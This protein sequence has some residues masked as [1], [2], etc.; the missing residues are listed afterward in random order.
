MVTL[1]DELRAES[2]AVNCN[3]YVPAAVKL[4]FVSAEVGLLNTADAGPLT[5]CHA[6][7]RAPPTGNPS[8]STTPR[9]TAPF[10]RVTVWTD[11]ASTKGALLLAPFQTPDDVSTS[12]PTFALIVSVPE[13]ANTPSAKR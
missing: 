3:T 9:R 1:A 8:S 12:A 7:V 6:L 13:N 10:G 2:D 5:C 4:T 11:P